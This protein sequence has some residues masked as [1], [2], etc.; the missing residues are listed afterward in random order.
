MDKDPQTFSARL[1]RFMKMVAVM[2]GALVLV[3]LVLKLAGVHYNDALLTTGFGTLA[4]V[5]FYLGKLFPAKPDTPMA[6]I[7]NFGMTLTGYGLA[8]ALIGLLFVLQHWPGGKMV[9][10]IGGGSLL[11][12]GLIWLYYFLR[13]NKQ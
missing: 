5:A 3:A 9:L 12:T 2:G 8:A 11:L 4:I 7:W 10:A 1:R 13:R 6:Q